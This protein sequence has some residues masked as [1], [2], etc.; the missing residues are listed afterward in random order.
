MQLLA[1]TAVDL[2]NDSDAK[3][4]DNDLLES[5]IDA[6]VVRGDAVLR[7]LMQGESQAAEWDYL[8]G[9][10]R[11]DNLPPP[12]DDAVYS[13]LR[14]RELIQVDGEIWRLRVPLMQCWLRA[15]A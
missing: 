8:C 12:D 4:L 13:S 2:L 14:R 11:Q 9:F 6:A 3:K 5:A 10:R 7:Q 15:R 1:E